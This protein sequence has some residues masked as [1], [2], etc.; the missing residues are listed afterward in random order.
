MTPLHDEHVQQR[1][2]V[3]EMDATRV[4]DWIARG[5][6]C[7]GLGYILETRRNPYA[8]EPMGPWPQAYRT[9]RH[10]S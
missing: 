5:R 7:L 10:D 2:R 3:I 9:A 4:A 6:P 1:R 8:V